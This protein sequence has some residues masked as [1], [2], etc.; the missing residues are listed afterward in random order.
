MYKR[1][2]VFGVLFNDTIDALLENPY[3]VAISLLLGGIVLLF[4]DRWFS[5]QRYDDVDG[6]PLGT[7]L[8]IGLFQCLAMVPGVSRSAASI[9]GG[10][11]QGV[12]RQA[13]AE[14][15]FFLAVPTMGAA[16]AKKIWDYFQ[17]GNVL[18]ARQWQLFGLGNVVAFVV[19]MLAIRFFIGYLSRHGFRVFGWYRIVVGGLL[20][21]LLAGGHELSIV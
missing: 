12:S 19:A 17:D 5:H 6:L 20:L 3:T 4:V 1:Q 10:M 13:A 9:I 14:F 18:T 7:A 8:K 11:S 16:T 2:V 15:S 21:A